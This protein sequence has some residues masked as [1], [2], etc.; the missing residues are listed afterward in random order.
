MFLLGPVFLS[1]ALT[2]LLSLSCLSRPSISPQ[3]NFLLTGFYKSV[4]SLIPHLPLA[5]PV[6]VFSVLGTHAMVHII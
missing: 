3:E 4:L 1:C 5:Y 6:G 2:H